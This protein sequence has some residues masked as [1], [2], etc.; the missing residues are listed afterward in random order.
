M[1]PMV[2]RRTWPTCSWE[3]PRGRLERRRRRVAVSRDEFIWGTVESVSTEGPCSDDG[4]TLLNAMM[5]LMLETL[6]SNMETTVRMAWVLNC[7][8]ATRTAP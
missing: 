6:K 7:R 5:A 8:E 3:E 2:E 1:G 4:G